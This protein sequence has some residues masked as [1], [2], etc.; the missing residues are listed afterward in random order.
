MIFLVLF[1]TG[2]ASS[3]TGLAEKITDVIG[4][5]EHS[6]CT[7]LC[8]D[9]SASEDENIPML[10]ISPGHL[11]SI[12]MKSVSCWIAIVGVDSFENEEANQTS[13]LEVA[14]SLK[15]SKTRH[16]FVDAKG[17]ID[18][19]AIKNFGNAFAQFSIFYRSESSRE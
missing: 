3:S 9:C 18:S 13:L 19:E 6:S 8:V 1:L 14:E 16:I 5:L 12:E 4:D 15:K 2:I 11:S 10:N 17:R 7:I